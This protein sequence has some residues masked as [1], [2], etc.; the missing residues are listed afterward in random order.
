MK[1]KIL[2]NKNRS[3]EKDA[4]FSR[5]ILID[6][7]TFIIKYFM[8][9]FSILVFLWIIIFSK[10]TSDL[11]KPSL[12]FLILLNKIICNTLKEI[13]EM[14]ERVRRPVWIGME[15]SMII[16]ITEAWRELRRSLSSQNEH[17]VASERA[18]AWRT[19]DSLKWIT[20]RKDDILIWNFWKFQ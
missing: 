8:I 20:I 18:A 2:I 19:S 15:S 10:G 6:T 3:I 7:S 5:E 12:I 4:E 14:T 1:L 17:K 13:W 16:S 9:N 11:G